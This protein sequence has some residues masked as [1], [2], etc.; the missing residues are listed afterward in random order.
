ML[1]FV[2]RSYT[3]IIKCPSLINLTAASVYMYIIRVFTNSYIRIVQ[4]RCTVVTLTSRSLSLRPPAALVQVVYRS[5]LSINAYTKMYI[6]FNNTSGGFRGQLI[7]AS[8]TCT[9]SH[10]DGD[11]VCALCAFR[12]RSAI[13]A[14]PTLCLACENMVGPSC[15]ISFASRSIT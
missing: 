14:M 9:S 13:S 3:T 11:C 15:R 6:T 2:K 10:V 1:L 4:M 5:Q 8:D 12:I 7:A